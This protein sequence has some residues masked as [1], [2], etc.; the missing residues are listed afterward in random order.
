[1]LRVNYEW[2]DD[3]HSTPEYRPDLFLSP[4]IW[5][6]DKIPSPKEYL[7]YPINRKVLPFKLREKAKKFIHIAGNMKAG[8]DRNGTKAFF[9]AIPL[10]KSNDIEII[11]KSQVPLTIN[12]KRV[13]VDVCNYEN[14]FDIWEDADVYVSPRRYAGQ[15]LPLNEAMSLGMAVIMTDMSPQNSFLPKELLIKPKMLSEIEIKNKKIEYDEIEPIE[16]AKK[17][18]EI[19]GKDITKYSMISDEI[20]TFWSWDNLINKYKK[21]LS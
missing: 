21:I 6:F 3:I 8:H 14:Y 10:I 7:P 13:R 5:E 4:S 20:A 16:I 15:S 2:L 18:D 17:I 19:A 9:Q 11:V 1:V 12:D